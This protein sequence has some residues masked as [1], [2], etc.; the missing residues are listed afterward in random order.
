MMKPIQ[1]FA[2][3]ALAFTG[4]QNVQAQKKKRTDFYGTSNID[5]LRSKVSDYGLIIS[6]GL[7][8]LMTI[9]DRRSILLEGTTNTEYYFRT[10]GKVAPAF[11]IGM[12][13]FA[14][15]SYLKKIRADHYDWALG[16]KTFQGW[17]ETNLII[18]NDP[19]SE[20]IGQ[21]GSGEF[22]LGYITGRYTLHQAFKIGPRVKFTHGLGINFDYRINGSERGDISNYQPPVLPITQTYQRDYLGQIHYE[23]GFR[24]RAINL[25]HIT[26]MLHVPLISAVQWSGGR[27]SIQ[28]FSSRYQPWMIKFKI[29]FPKAEKQ[30][31]CPATYG[32][33]DDEKRNKEY[34]EGK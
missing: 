33:P 30:G 20:A 16:Y 14:K 15:K 24:L 25:I 12:L 31:K 17:E 26:P 28:W 6:V 34:M 13:H 3:F 11:E 7:T 29:L 2:I 22:S 21:K 19:N 18:R 8:H 5:L 10:G 32:N 27:S 4:I 23:I 9:D 1:I